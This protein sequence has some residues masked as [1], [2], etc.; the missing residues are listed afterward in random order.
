M[1]EPVR[2]RYPGPESFRDDDLDR[3]LFQGRTGDARRLVHLTLAEDVV[4]LYAKSGTGKTSLINTKL[5]QPLRERQ[6]LPVV[7]R[8]RDDKITP[9]E[10]IFAAV[11]AAGEKYGLELV[12]GDH[13][14]LLSGT[15]ARSRSGGRTSCSRRW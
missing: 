6:F 10:A 12:D 3:V 13:A 7:A 2:H 9:A 1:S 14:S 11:R 4:V 15:S 8:V 5:L